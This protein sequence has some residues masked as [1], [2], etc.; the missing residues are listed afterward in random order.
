MFMPVLYDTLMYLS[1]PIIISSGR[2]DLFWRVLKKQLP[3]KKPALRRLLGN[4]TEW[5]IK[6]GPW[7]LRGSL[8]PQSCGL[9]C[10]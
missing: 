2:L 4:T 8:R 3:V 1:T 5:S 10:Q 7:P 6:R 9:V